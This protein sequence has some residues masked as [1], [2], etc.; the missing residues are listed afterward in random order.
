[1]TL[2][3][4]GLFSHPSYGKG[5]TSGYVA[6]S[7]ETPPAL[8]WV[9]LDSNTYEMRLGSKEDSEGHVCGKFSWTEGKECISLQG[10]EQWL[11]VQ[12]PGRGKLSDEIEENRPWKLYCNY[13]NSDMALPVGAQALKIRLERV[14]ASS[15]D[16]VAS[17]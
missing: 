6:V 16:A 11:A 14:S 10:Q 17:S 5:N 13:G 15:G 7:A 3:K 9:F 2:F 1:M 4:G 12:L 8:R